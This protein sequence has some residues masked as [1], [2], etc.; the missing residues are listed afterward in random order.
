MKTADV[1]Y[2]P[3]SKR[4]LQ[5]PHGHSRFTVAQIDAGWARVRELMRKET[6]LHAQT[7][8]N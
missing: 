6:R 7:P 5:R 8:A 4:K 2:R 1:K 3:A